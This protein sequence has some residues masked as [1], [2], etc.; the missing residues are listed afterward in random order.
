VKIFLR[1]GLTLGWLVALGL[2][3]P[4]AAEQGFHFRVPVRISHVPVGVDGVRVRCCATIEGSS[5]A[6]QHAD[7][8]LQAG[9]QFDRNVSVR[10][11]TPRPEVKY[12]D[13]YCWLS[14]P[15]DTRGREF[16]VTGEWSH[17]AGNPQ[18]QSGKGRVEGTLRGK[19]RTP[20]KEGFQLR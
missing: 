5:P 3:A 20:P 12:T 9:G 8:P 15:A 10:V 2:A 6:C 17:G 1:H 16:W 19:I 18:F 13:Y 4:A 7:F 11:E 14:N